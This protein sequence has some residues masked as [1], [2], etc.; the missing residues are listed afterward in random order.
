MVKD[1][2]NTMQ[3]EYIYPWVASP[4]AGP[5]SRQLPSIF[6][7]YASFQDKRMSHDV[8][9]GAHKKHSEDQQ[10]SSGITFIWI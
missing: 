5:P 10:R 9:L 8:A 6:E 3:F 7:G 2:H 4:T 1:K